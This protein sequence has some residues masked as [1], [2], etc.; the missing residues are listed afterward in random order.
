MLLYRNLKKKRDRETIFV[1]V[2]TDDQCAVKS[3]RITGLG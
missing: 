1:L 2:D 3:E